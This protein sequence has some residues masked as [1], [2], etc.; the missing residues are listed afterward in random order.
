MVFTVLII[1]Y[2]C[3]AYSRSRLNQAGW[4]S[5]APQARDSDLNASGGY[6][7][8]SSHGFGHHLI[9]FKNIRQHPHGHEKSS[10][11]GSLLQTCQPWC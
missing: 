11:N 3:W 1:L 4:R 9:C 7:I 10:Q 2:T 5:E 6:L 8:C